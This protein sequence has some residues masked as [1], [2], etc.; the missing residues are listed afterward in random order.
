LVRRRYDDELRNESEGGL[1]A[2]TGGAESE[3]AAGDHL[4][5]KRDASLKRYVLK[6]EYLPMGKESGLFL[7]LRL[8]KSA[9]GR[10]RDADS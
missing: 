3:R 6:R 1:R 7:A 8:P 9:E 2:A 5:L 4:F 10:G